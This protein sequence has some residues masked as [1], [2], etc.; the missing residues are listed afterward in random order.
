MNNGDSINGN[1][2]VPAQNETR[3]FAE[4]LVIR[5]SLS[6]LAVT[7]AGGFQAGKVA[8]VAGSNPPTAGLVPHLATLCWPWLPS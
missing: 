8:E 1:E 4:L 2:Y 3:L 6:N 7:V 5:Q